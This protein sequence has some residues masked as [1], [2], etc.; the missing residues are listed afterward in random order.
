MTK[1]TAAQA[2]PKRLGRP[3]V[4]ADKAKSEAVLIKMTPAQREKLAA[5]G[6]PEWVRQRI[7][8]A[9]APATELPAP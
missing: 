9:Q 6:G 8:R 4:P 3:P 7:D 1:S 5:L 2:A